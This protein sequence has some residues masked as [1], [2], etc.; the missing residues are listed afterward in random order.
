MMHASF[1]YYQLLDEGGFSCGQTA[2]WL[3]DDGTCWDW[4]NVKVIEPP[5]VSLGV[6]EAFIREAA[7]IYTLCLLIND[8]YELGPEEF[9]I[10]G[11]PAVETLKRIGVKLMPEVSRLLE[12]VQAYTKNLQLGEIDIVLD[13][14]FEKYVRGRFV[15]LVKR[16]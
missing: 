4:L 6:N 7:L 9:Q 2:F 1:F 16:R 5:N 15:R 12:C 11:N 13:E 8:L 3:F 10:R 14:I